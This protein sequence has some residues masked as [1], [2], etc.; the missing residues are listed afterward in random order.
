MKQFKHSIPFKQLDFSLNMRFFPT[1]S[2]FLD[3]ETTGFSPSKNRCYLIGTAY[4]TDSELLFEQFFAENA[5]QEPAILE[6]FSQSASHFQTIIFFNGKSFDLPFLEKR[7]KKYSNDFNYHNLYYVDLFS[8]A[9]SLKHIFQL[10]NYKQKT[11]ETYLGIHREDR[12]SGG[13]LTAVY[14]SYE[15]QPDAESLK[16][17]LQHNRDDVL[18]MVQLLDLLSYDSLF[19]GNFEFQKA[20]LEEYQT[21]EKKQGLELLIQ[22]RLHEKIP[23]ALTCKNEVFY[24]AA[25]ESQMVFR[26]P[27]EQGSLKYFYPDY[28]N[29]YYLPEED[30]AIH[31]SVA[32]YVDKGHKVKATRQTCYGKKDGLF[33]PQLSE[34]REPIFY[35]NYQ[36]KISYFEYTE[37]ADVLAAYCSYILNCLRHT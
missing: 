25:K 36:D 34:F 27:A 31:K 22:T 23:K 28:K 37:E 17:L 9:S 26:I 12:Y 32:A 8:I 1:D 13:E 11:L 2:I 5:A 35:K 21:Y 16:L 18:G 19:Q 7:A 29:Y 15:K 4:R 6:A 3:I 33:L 20:S 30:L 14:H 10:E 24:C